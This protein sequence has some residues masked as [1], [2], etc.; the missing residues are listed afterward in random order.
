MR[1]IKLKKEVKSEEVELELSNALNKIGIGVFGPVFKIQ[2]TNINQVYPMKVMSK[3]NLPKSEQLK[4]ALVESRILKLLDHLFIISMHY[5]FQ[6]PENIYFVIDYC[7]LGD[8]SY[9]IGIKLSFKEGKALFYI[10]ELILA[11]E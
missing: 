5:A 6:T 9:H 10:S 8:L 1:G 11:I 7:Q 2:D 3:S 4:F